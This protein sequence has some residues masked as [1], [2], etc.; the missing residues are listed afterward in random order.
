MARMTAGG[1]LLTGLGLSA[2]VGLL[3]YVVA[4]AGS[5]RNAA[6]IP[7]SIEARLDKVVDTL[8]RQYGKQWVAFALSALQE[9]LS[10]LLP[11]HLVALVAAVYKAEQAH[12]GLRGDVKR[13]HATQY[14][15]QMGMA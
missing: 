7:D 5:E 14:A 13:R 4:G 8:N 6:L 11:A 3:Y 2:V 15:H 1:K 12:W 10:K 9:G